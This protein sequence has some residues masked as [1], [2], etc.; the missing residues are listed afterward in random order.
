MERQ[1]V[2]RLGAVMP[3]E[4]QLEDAPPEEIGMRMGQAMQRLAEPI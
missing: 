2:E 1:R 3:L 4:C